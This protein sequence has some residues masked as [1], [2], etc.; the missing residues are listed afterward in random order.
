[1]SRTYKM[2]KKHR[3]AISRGKTGKKR[4][5]FTPEHKDNLRKAWV[6]RKERQNKKR[7]KEN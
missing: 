4:K 5:P 7:E 2:S 3:D 1:M 6:I